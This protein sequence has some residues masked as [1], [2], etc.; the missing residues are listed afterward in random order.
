MPW[1]SDWIT[2]VSRFPEQYRFSS[3]YLWERSR[4]IYNGSF[5]C[6]GLSR[7]SGI[8]SHEFF[9]HQCVARLYR[10]QPL[11]VSAEQMDPSAQIAVCEKLTGTW[12]YSREEEPGGRAF[13]YVG[14]GWFVD[15]V[16][17]SV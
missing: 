16:L 7:N 8:T 4:G 13:L 15:F 1:R 12:F 3:C 14:N 17:D 6:P 2:S 10:D 5:G 9:A 11:T